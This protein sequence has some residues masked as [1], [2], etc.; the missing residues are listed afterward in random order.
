MVRENCKK[1][2]RKNKK[3]AAFNEE[4]TEKEDSVKREKIIREI[5]K[6]K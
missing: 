4:E 6:G 1:R 2:E 3:K 5:F